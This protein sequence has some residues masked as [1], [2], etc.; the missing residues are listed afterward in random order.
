M[1]DNNGFQ[2]RMRVPHKNYVVHGQVVVEQ[3]QEVA[4]D[5]IKVGSSGK[6]LHVIPFDCACR[7]IERRSIERACART[8]V[9]ASH[10]SSRVALG[11]GTRTWLSG[12]RPENAVVSPLCRL[13][14][15]DPRPLPRPSP[16]RRLDAPLCRPLHLVGM[17]L[18][19]EHQD[20]LALDGVPHPAVRG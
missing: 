3:C 7:S 14:I 20:Q 19:G 5:H 15:L 1:Q 13:I 4:L 2:N 10:A 18:L 16:Y 12:L 8:T 9:C 11:R 6:D 17:P